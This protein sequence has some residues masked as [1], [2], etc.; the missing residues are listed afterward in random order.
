MEVILVGLGTQDLVE[1]L[2]DMVVLVE[3]VVILVEMVV[4]YFH[5]VVLQLLVRKVVEVVV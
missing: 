1:V 3:T 5:L 4:V 2:L